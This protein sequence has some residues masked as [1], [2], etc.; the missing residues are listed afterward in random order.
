MGLLAVPRAPVLGAQPR[1]DADQVEDVATARG[2]TGPGRRGRRRSRRRR[3]ALTAPWARA[4]DDGSV[5]W[6][7]WTCSVCGS[8]APNRGFTSIAPSSMN[9]RIHVANV[10]PARDGEQIV[11]DLVERGDLRV[12]EPDHVPAELGLDGLADPAG[13]ERHRGLGE[14]GDELR[15]RRRRERA[16]VLGGARIDRLLLGERQEVVARSLRAP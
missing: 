12:L 1:L 10:G 7:R 9:V 11:A 16:A 4:S 14:L 3:D 6:T 5:L 8:S 2:T 13:R 15:R